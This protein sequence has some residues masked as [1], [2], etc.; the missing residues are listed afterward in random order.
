MTKKHGLGRG[1]GG[2]ISGAK[3]R[4][5]A[6]AAPEK[7]AASA[8]KSAP[9]HATPFC[10]IPVSQIAPSPH[11]ARREF[12]AEGLREL[13][14]SIRSEGLLQPLVVR[15]NGDRYLL[16]AG[17]R[18]LRAVRALGLR[19]VYA[20]VLEA[21]EASSAVMGLIENLQRRDLN[22]IETALGIASLMKDFGLTQESVAERLGQPRAT[23]ANT[24]RLLSLE[25]EIQTYITKGTLSVGHAKVLL[26]LEDRDLRLLVARKAIEESMSVRETELE[27]LRA[28]RDV[29]K[30][31]A[32]NTPAQAANAVIRDLEKRLSGA[33]N[34]A[35]FLKH[36]PKHGKLIIEYHGNED[37]QR[38]LEK[39]GLAK[40]L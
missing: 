15:K 37:L 35:V 12:D 24:L 21:G 27:V 1:L 31:I 22:P 26:G 5:A 3:P 13:A 29:G 20:C 18:R 32:R 40:S 34:T 30:K 14:D 2:L 38:I 4:P 25:R 11:Q 10:E 17:E 8:P 6:P 33:L 7:P 36:A 19:S 23:V 16:I 28:K 9:A 39:L